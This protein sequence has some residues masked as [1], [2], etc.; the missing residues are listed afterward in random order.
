MRQV[1]FDK[2]YEVLT[3]DIKKI[4]KLFGLMSAEN[5]CLKQIM[6]KLKT[7]DKQACTQGQYMLKQFDNLYKVIQ[8]YFNYVKKNPAKVKLVF[9]Y[10]LN[11]KENNFF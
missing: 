6:E 7:E 4:I 5:D 3:K 10:G 9:F 8:E 2:I 11:K 1:E